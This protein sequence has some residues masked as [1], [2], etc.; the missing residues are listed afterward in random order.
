MFTINAARQRFVPSCESNNR[1]PTDILNY[2]IGWYSLPGA[3]PLNG[4]D[5]NLQTHN[6][7]GTWQLFIYDLTG[8]NSGSLN[9][10]SLEF[11]GN[12]IY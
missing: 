10:W 4:W 8:K 7:N 2:S 11:Q 1:L 3:P 9:S 12:W 5:V 6:P